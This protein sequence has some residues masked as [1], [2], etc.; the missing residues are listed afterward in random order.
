MRQ[1]AMSQPAVCHR[2]M[3]QPAERVAVVAVA[4]Q[5]SAAAAAVVAVPAGLCGA[6]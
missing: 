4:A 2:A 1:W 3:A 5:L 6:Q